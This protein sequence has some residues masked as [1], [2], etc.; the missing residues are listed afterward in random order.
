MCNTPPNSHRGRSRG[1]KARHLALPP[2]SPWPK[3]A[4]SSNSRCCAERTERARRT[5]PERVGF[6][7]P[8]VLVLRLMPRAGTLRL[9]FVVLF[10]W[11]WEV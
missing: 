6:A 9:R 3:Q 7:V 11:C 10:A 5:V 1:E 2:W 8:L 4:E